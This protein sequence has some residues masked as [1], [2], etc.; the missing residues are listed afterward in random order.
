M[1][2]TGRSAQKK[3]D[4]EAKAD[5]CNGKE[6]QRGLDKRKIEIR[7]RLLWFQRSAKLIS[8]TRLP[9]SLPNCRVPRS[10]MQS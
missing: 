6:Q 2:W 8:Q 9:G 3:K 7:K 4:A 5:H 1:A 10:I